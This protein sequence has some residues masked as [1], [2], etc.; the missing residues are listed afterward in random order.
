MFSLYYRKNNNSRLFSQL[1]NTGFSN[2]QNYVPIYSEFFELNQSNYS[3]INLNSKYSIQ[4]I[5]DSHNNNHFLINVVN[6][7]GETTEKGSFFK[8]SPLLNPLKYLT[9]RYK[10]IDSSS[11][12]IPTFK[13]AISKK[14]LH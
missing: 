3:L 4:S 8:F 9:G 2:V 1:E 5:E 6:E 10:T 11:N 7:K 14:D 12:L 13:P